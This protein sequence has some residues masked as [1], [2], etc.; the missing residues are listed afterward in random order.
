VNNDLNDEERK[1]ERG[2]RDGRLTPREARRLKRMLWDARAL[3]RDALYDGRLT[4]EEEADLYWAEREL[5]R[6]IRW[7]LNDFEQW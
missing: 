3:E 5:N 7:E 4:Y 2:L 1:I 6:E